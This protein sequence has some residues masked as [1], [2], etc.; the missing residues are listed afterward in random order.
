MSL[1][2]ASGSPR[3]RDIL[4]AA[5]YRIAAV[6]P[7]SI[8][9]ERQA[10]ESPLDYTARLS[11]EKALDQARPGYWVLG[12]DTVVHF[13]DWVLE[14]PRDPREAHAMLTRLSGVWHR[15]TT[16]WSLVRGSQGEPLIHSGQCTSSVRFRELV[17]AE[18]AAYVATGEGQD[19]AGSYG[20]QGLGAA[21]VS[22]VQ[23]S[24]SNVVG[25]PMEQ[26]SSALCAIGIRPKGTT[27]EH[28]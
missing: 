14:K 16:S 1:I 11:K 17:P 8:T 6:C 2:L 4:R 15:V 22:E 9:E 19:K 3:R 20:I 5:G 10:G 21:L 18:I 24:Y 28:R 26:L 27:D 23:G 12:A 13:E 25:L 7:S